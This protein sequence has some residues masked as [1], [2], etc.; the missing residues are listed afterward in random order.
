[1]RVQ[2]G[3]SDA[4][5]VYSSTPISSQMGGHGKWERIAGSFLLRVG[6]WCCCTLALLLR[7]AVDMSQDLVKQAEGSGEGLGGAGERA[8]GR[9]CQEL[10]RRCLP[11]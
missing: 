10:G 3:G 11:R 4:K 2:E 8:S 9:S 1:M 7:T 5:C 6:H